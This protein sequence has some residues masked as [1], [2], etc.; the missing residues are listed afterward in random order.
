VHYVFRRGAGGLQRLHHAVH[1][2]L[3]LRFEI[4]VQV[5]QHLL[6]LVR[7]VV[8]DGQRGTAGQPQDLPALDLDRR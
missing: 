1:R 2:A 8:V 7:M 3:H 5:L 4:V 6:A